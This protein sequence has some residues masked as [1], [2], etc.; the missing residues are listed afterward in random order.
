MH[1]A[2]ENYKAGTFFAQKNNRLVINSLNDWD[3][4]YILFRT[5]GGEESTVLNSTSIY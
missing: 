3:I 4:K 2:T 1:K 5:L